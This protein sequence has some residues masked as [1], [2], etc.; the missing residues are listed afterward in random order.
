[1]RS[2]TLSEEL[3]ERYRHVQNSEEEVLK[4]ESMVI[5]A[6]TLIYCT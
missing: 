2:I 3:G 5:K 4:Y 1:M 6:S